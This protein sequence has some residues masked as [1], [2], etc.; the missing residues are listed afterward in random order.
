LKRVRRPPPNVD[1]YPGGLVEKVK[2]VEMTVIATAKP[3]G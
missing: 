3:E 2:D 1:N